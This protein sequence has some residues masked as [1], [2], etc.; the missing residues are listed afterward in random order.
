[1]RKNLRPVGGK[2]TGL[3]RVVVSSEDA[4]ILAVARAWGAETPFVRPAGLASDTTPGVDPVLHALDELPGYDYV[5]LLQPTSPLRQAA[6]IE[7]CL[8][9][10]L[11][12]GAPACISVALA[13]QSPYWMFR[14]DG[15]GRLRPLLD[16]PSP[17]R[18]QDLPEVYAITGALYVAR[19]DW[20]RERKTFVTPETVGY[21]MPAERSL[22]LDTEDDFE[23]LRIRLE[24]Q[25]G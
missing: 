14:L 17:P 6:D 8:R 15:D 18:R 20:L 10:T 24:Q 2:P 21:V 9:Q 7:A 5:V 22:D 3:D 13:E 25:H 12:R 23:L 4:E 16:A 1:L 19:V 11:E